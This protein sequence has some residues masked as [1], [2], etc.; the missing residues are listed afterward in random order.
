[1]TQMQ[2]ELRDLGCVCACGFNG[3]ASSGQTGTRSLTGIPFLTRREIN[4]LDIFV[5]SGTKGGYLWLRQE[6]QMSLHS[7]DSDTGGGR[8]A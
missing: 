5:P 2:L 6:R 8:G 7:C 4:C 3:K 1:M